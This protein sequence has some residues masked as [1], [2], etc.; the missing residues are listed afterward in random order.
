MKRFA[1]VVATICVSMMLSCV[2]AANSVV[3]E[4]VPSDNVVVDKWGD[5]RDYR[6]IPGNGL[7][8]F[9][10]PDGDGPWE[11]SEL[12][13]ELV[14]TSVPHRH[15]ENNF[16]YFMIDDDIAY[17]IPNGTRVVV[18]V[19]YYD[20]GFEAF[21]LG[22]DSWA[23][24]EELEGAFKQTPIPFSALNTHQWKVRSFEI[25]DARFA[26]RTHTGDFR[27]LVRPKMIIRRVTVEIFL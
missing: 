4:W 20:A 10:P 17:E 13:G 3:V 6:I 9:E 15:H 1:L 16:F 7:D 21:L 2:V 11:L 26:N 22:Y 23:T 24:W 14:V 12:D 19:E 5:G 18:S 25:K 8:L 27:I